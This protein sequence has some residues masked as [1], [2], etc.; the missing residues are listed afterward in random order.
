MI[1]A[2]ISYI[3]DLLFMQKVASFR[4]IRGNWSSGQREPFATDWRR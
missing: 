3:G 4:S 2:V 1:K